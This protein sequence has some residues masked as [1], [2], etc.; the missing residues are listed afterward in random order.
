MDE[1]TSQMSFDFDESEK[2]LRTAVG[3]A[4]DPVRYGRSFGLRLV[5]QETLCGTELLKP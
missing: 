1:Y 4:G 5:P 2:T 3:T